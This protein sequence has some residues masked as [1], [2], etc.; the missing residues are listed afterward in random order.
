MIN[1]RRELCEK[2]RYFRDN[3][4][5]FRFGDPANNIPDEALLEGKELG[6][7]YVR[8]A[9]ERAFLEILQFK[10]NR[11]GLIASPCFRSIR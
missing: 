10:G 1:R 9:R 5:T 3:F 2:R 8:G 7:V 11:V 6:G 4:P